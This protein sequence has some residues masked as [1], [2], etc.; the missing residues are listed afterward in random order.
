RGFA[1]RLEAHAQDAGVVG[2][3]SYWRG[4]LSGGS[5]RLIDEE[6]DRGRDVLGSARHLRLTLPV[7]VT[8]SLLTRVPA[9]FRCGIEDVLL[10]GLA[11]ALAQ[12]W[13]QRQGAGV[14]GAGEAVPAVLLDVEGHGRHEELFAGVDLSRTVGWFTSLYPVR[15]DVGGLDV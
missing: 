8:A 15:L 3:L 7:E 10:G 5:L 2:E 14:G 4:V 1:Q 6:L 11:L 12:W 9:V 13:R